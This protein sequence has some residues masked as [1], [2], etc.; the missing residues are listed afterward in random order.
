MPVHLDAE[1]VYPGFIFFMER[2]EIGVLAEYDPAVVIAVIFEARKIYVY[3]IA[4]YKNLY[5]RPA[6][7]VGYKIYYFVRVQ[8]PPP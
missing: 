1:A 8:N 4:F 3:E 2:F 7:R 6:L 5:R